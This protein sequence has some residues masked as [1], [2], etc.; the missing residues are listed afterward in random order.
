MPELSPAD[1]DEILKALAHAQRR[2]IL[3]WLKTPQEAFPTHQ[4]PFD[5][6]V[7]AGKIHEKSGLSASTM[8][9]HLAVLQRTGLVSTQK[10]GQWIYYSRNEAVI[11]A[12]KRQM[13]EV[14]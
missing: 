5:A 9:A 14:F 3:V 12:F 8:S 1:I 2:Q 7:C 6:G 11:D 4:H 10:I 13:P